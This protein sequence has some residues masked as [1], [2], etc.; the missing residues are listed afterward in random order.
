MVEHE[1][2]PLQQLAEGMDDLANKCDSLGLSSEA[3][4]L[5]ESVIDVFRH[6]QERDNASYTPFLAASLYMLATRQLQRNMRTEEAASLRECV[7]LYRGLGQTH[8]PQLASALA[9]L[10]DVQSYLRQ[11]HD[12][13]RTLRELCALHRKLSNIQPNLYLVPLTCSLNNLSNTLGRSSDKADRREALKYMLEAIALHNSITADMEPAS[14]HAD[15]AGFLIN[16]SLRLAALGRLKEALASNKRA[17]AIY[18][19]LKLENADYATALCNLSLRLQQV[20][21]TLGSVRAAKKAL[22]LRRSL[23]AADDESYKLDLARSLE[24]YAFALAAVSKYRDALEAARECVRVY[25]ELF[26]SGRRGKR[27]FGKAVKL[28]AM[29]LEQVG[30]E[31]S[32]MNAFDQPHQQQ[33][34]Q[35]SS[36]RTRTDEGGSSDQ[37]RGLEEPF[38][39]GQ[40]VSAKTWDSGLG[41]EPGGDPFAK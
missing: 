17:I 24:R 23:A 39:S 13:L 9:Q 12:E 10:S 7:E 18:H 5:T 38:S 31:S 4:E 41:P 14:R 21:N 32:G 3:L 33:Q 25:R 16:L 40:T 20:G 15:L 34:Q 6:L 29:L 8:A 28:M 22:A 37:Q 35:G 30:R 19:S 2:V 36:E 27:R 1:S 11:Y 26:V